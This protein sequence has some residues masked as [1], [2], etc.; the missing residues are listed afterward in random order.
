MTD[1]CS[2][3]SFVDPTRHLAILSPFRSA[4]YQSTNRSLTD[5]SMSM[6]QSEH[7]R[8]ALVVDD[9]SDVTEMLAVLMTHAGYQV[10]TASSAPDAIAM[11]RDHRFDLV[12]SDIG[13]PGMNGYELAEAL[14][15]LPGYEDIPMVAVTGFSRY[16][17]RSRSLTAGFTEHVTKPID[18]RAFLALLEHL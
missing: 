3:T 11:A 1:T 5:T 8:W 18:P 10:S 16:D 6:N 9:I 2:S 7:R 17:D 15:R 13:M 4:D 14:R 12:I